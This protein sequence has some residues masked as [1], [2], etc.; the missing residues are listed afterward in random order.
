M[1]VV[2]LGET[3][4]EYIEKQAKIIA[5][6]GKLS[7]FDGDVLKIY[8]NLTGNFEEN[9]KFIKRVI[10]MGHD[11]ITDHDYVVFA[12]KDVSIL[13]EQII[14]E[15]RFSSFTIKSRRE[16]DFSNVGYYVPDFHNQENQIVEMNQELQT[17][18]KKHMNMLF[19]EYHNLTEQGI[20]VEDARYILPYSFHSNIIMG[21]DAHSLKDL[22]ISLTK[23]KNSN[24]TELRELGEKLYDIMKDRASYIQDAIDQ[25]K[26]KNKDAV[27]EFLNQIMFDRYQW[28]QDEHLDTTLLLSST[29]K[30]DET[31]FISAIMK[32][33]GYSYEKSFELYQTY[34]NG[35]EKSRKELKSKL[36]KLIL[37]EQE[38]L[39]NINF[40]FQIPISLANLTH[41][42][43]HRTVELLIPDFVPIKDLKRYKAPKSI[44]NSGY[45]LEKI[46]EQ[47]QELYNMFKNIGVRD[48]DLVYFYLS[49]NMLNVVANMDGKTLSHILRLRCCN[50]AQWE[51]R[52]IANEMRSLV[53][54]ESKY[55]SNILG[56]T[57][58]TEGI[59][60]EGKESCGK[61]KKLI[62]KSNNEN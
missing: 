18:Y 24:I 26:Q 11:S 20:K 48:E 50:K 52:N 30:I 29:K 56:P 57:C 32:T 60:Y 10:K 19:S 5:S 1:E 9:I 58:E 36:M 15:Q 31:I 47:N 6:A 38:A 53:T 8:E 3:S 49:G 59:C 42:T 28:L 17:I 23:G 14:I 61:I 22:I 4:K 21:L 27:E 2:L 54:D 13:V 16:V 62:C 40:S 34:L 41:L 43:R 37:K 44:I 39:K 7:R 12:L 45:H 46:F 55:F 25:S 35:N 33:F 51:I